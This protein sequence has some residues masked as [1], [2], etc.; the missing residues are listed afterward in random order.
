LKALVGTVT[1]SQ[2]TVYCDVL[3]DSGKNVED[4]R[5]HSGTEK[6]DGTM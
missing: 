5:G 1:Q 4:G 3:T 2:K 6:T